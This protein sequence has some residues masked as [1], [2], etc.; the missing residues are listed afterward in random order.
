MAQSRSYGP[1]TIEQWPRW[2]ADCGG[3]G[4]KFDPR[5]WVPWLDKIAPYDPIF[6]VVPDRF[7]PTDIGGNF[8]ATQAMWAHWVDQVL[9]RGLRAAWVAQNGARTDDIPPDASAVF[10]GGDDT[11]KTSEQAW[12][13]VSTAKAHG[14]WTHMGRVNGLPKF[15][16][17]H[18]SGLDSADG[19]VLKYGYNANLPR[20]L[21]WL[22]AT[23]AQQHLPIGGDAG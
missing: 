3:Y 11:W 1:T 16:A 5:R 13:I 14:L 15:R 18:I 2:A 19:N 6:V 23:D 8:A 17:G 7:D 22:D 12:A 10:I 4:G 21:A 20:L 9:D